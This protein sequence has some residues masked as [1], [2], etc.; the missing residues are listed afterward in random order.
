MQFGYRYA[1]EFYPFLFLL[2][3]KGMGTELKWHHM[4]IIALS[5]VV[6]LWAMLWIYEFGADM[7]NG[8]KWYEFF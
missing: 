4:L 7:T 5:V 1:L 8:W 3:M 6:N 2:T